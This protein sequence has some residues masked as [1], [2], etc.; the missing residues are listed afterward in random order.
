MRR[1][2]EGPRYHRLSSALVLY[3]AKDVLESSRAALSVPVRGMTGPY[4]KALHR[5]LHPRDTPLAAERDVALT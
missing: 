3:S 2:G 4:A 5:A 1:R